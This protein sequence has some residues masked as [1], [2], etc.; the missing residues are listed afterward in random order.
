MKQFFIIFLMALAL[1]GCARKDPE[2]P[3]G[4][5]TGV[6]FNDINRN[7]I[8][9]VG[10]PG[11]AGVRVSNGRDIVP[12]DGNGQYQLQ[13]EDGTIVFVIKPRDWMTPVNEVNLPHFYYIHK[14]NGSPYGL[15][16]PGT[17]PT[18]P[19]PESID[20][21]LYRHPEPERFEVVIFGDPQVSKP[22]E[23][24]YLAHDA[25][26]EVAGIKAAFGISLGDIVSNNL[27]DFASV[28]EIISLIG[29]PWYNVPGNHDINFY[30]Q[31]DE[32]SL[33]TFSRIYGPAYYS[34]DYGPVHFLVLDS[35]VAYKDQGE[36]LVY[37]EG[38][39]SKQLEFIRNDLSLLDSK[40]LVVLLLH[41][42]EDLFKQGRRE[43]FEVLEKHP[44]TVSVAGHVHRTEHLFLGPEHDWH[45]KN[46]H[47]LY[48]SGAVCGAW[49]MGIPDEVGIAHSMMTNGVPNGYSVFSFDGNRYTIRFKVFRRSAHY[50]MNIMAPEEIRAG[51]V[52]DN[53]VVVNVFAG[54]ERSKV[55]MRIGE[56]GGWVAMERILRKDPYF[57]Q[58]RK[59]EEQYGISRVWWSV[60]PED[61][62]HIWRADLPDNLPKG[63]HFIHIR[64]TDMF[65]KVHTGR[66]LI[67][68][69]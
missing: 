28:N 33:E 69:K 61:S 55:E 29:L 4:D 30:A 27:E 41:G 15:K 57:V 48:I 65:G 24:N 16:Y 1:T 5:A 62:G 54:S 37:H 52:V 56:S 43:L 59:L 19:Q 40:Q 39:D 10:E 45:G 42:A 35:I 17:A 25:V 11:I 18:G 9:D 58:M 23:L 63:V 2:I 53:E 8:R 67:R 7:G 50:Q 68:V 51:E 34:F 47:H 20:F 49:W 6:V 26:E 21:G 22:E 31:G 46:P 12:T 64:T 38:L 32:H 14:P 60:D 44:Y 13:V 36:Q 66:R 3:P